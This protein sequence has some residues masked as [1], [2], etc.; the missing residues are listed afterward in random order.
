MHSCSIFGR[1]IVQVRSVRHDQTARDLASLAGEESLFTDAVREKLGLLLMELRPLGARYDIV[2]AN[3]PYMGS[4]N[5]NSWLN[6]WSKKHYPEACKDLCTCFIKRGMSLATDRGYEALITSDTC[7]YIS[8]FEKMRKTVI[9]EASIVAF[10]DT[11]GTNA[12]PDVFDANAGWVLWLG[13]YEGLKGA[14]FKLNQTIA[15]KE[16][17]YLES[18]AN[19]ECGWFYRAEA[20]GF[21]EIPGSPIAYW[22]SSKMIGNYASNRTAAEHGRFLNGM[23]TGKN[24][25]VLRYWFEVSLSAISFHSKSESEFFSTGKKYA[26][27]NKGGE[28]RKW[29]GNQE[30]VIAYDNESN[31]LM[32][33]FVGHRH[34][35]SDT[36]FRT[37]L[38]WSKISSGVLAMRFFPSGFVY[39][40]AGCSLFCSEN[41]EMHLLLA[42]FNSCIAMRYLQILSPTLNF[43]AGQIRKIPYITPTKNEAESID[44]LSRSAI[45]TSKEDWSHFETAWDFKK[46]PLI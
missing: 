28:Y 15:E 16:A 10:I 8:S 14:Y 29:W 44:C 23:S 42:L 9:N 26:P 33:S 19:P 38:S 3:P 35:N 46:H 41:S 25:A 37:C 18:L 4:N 7:M 21:A 43:E 17:R 12:H 36:Y 13:K 1:R 27:Y 5:T 40:V 32:D 22:A 6:K 2:V 39:D 11:R 20:S 30:S 45:N 34:N 31:E 24:E